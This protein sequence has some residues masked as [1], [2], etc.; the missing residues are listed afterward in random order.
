VTEQQHPITPPPELVAQIRSDALH[1]SDNQLDYVLRIID[2]AF[3]SGADQ[4][5]EACEEWMRSHFHGMPQWAD[6]FRAARR[7]KPPSLAEQALE[8]LEAEDDAWPVRSLEKGR[9]F[10]TIRAALERLQ[11]LESKQ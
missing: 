7:P 8:A 10:D 5:L 4:E 6:Q 3:R 1:G 9:L 11:E 2:A